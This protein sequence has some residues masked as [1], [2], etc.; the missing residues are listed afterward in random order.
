MDRGRKINIMKEINEIIEEH[1]QDVL[2]ALMIEHLGLVELEGIRTIIK[3]YVL[4]DVHRITDELDSYVDI[5]LTN[6]LLSYYNE[7]GKGNNI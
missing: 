4:N 5:K 6:D 1:I 2:N 3:K 7:L